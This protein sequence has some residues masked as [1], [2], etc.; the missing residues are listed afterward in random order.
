M[1]HEKH[2]STTPKKPTKQPAPK[3]QE[4]LEPAK[5]QPSLQSRLNSQGKH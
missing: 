5:A 1:S 3:G 2:E 4:S